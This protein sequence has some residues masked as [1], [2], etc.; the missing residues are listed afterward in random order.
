KRDR[1][2]HNLHRIFT[3]A[4]YDLRPDFF[5][6]LDGKRVRPVDLAGG[7]N[8]QICFGNPDAAVFAARKAAEFFDANPD[9]ASF[10]VAMTDTRPICECSD[11][12]QWID[13]EKSFRGLPDYSDLVFTFMNRAAE[14]LV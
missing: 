10:S 9:E 12:Q 4:V 8:Y 7:E 3:E 14:E 5:I 1:F 11:C 6:M 2:N 13:H